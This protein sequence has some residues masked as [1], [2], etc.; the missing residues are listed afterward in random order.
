VAELYDQARPSYPTQLIDNLL[1]LSGV[2]KDQ[3]VLEIGPGTGQLT[4]PLAERGLS[5][6]AVE[7][8]TN[9]ARVARSKLARFDRVEIIVA[10]FN[11]WPLPRQPFDLVVAATAF[12][13][14]DPV[15]RLDRCVQ[16]LRPGGWLAIIDTHW[17]AAVADD[18]FVHASQACYARLDPDHDP[19]A[20]PPGPAG[21]P[22]R[23]EDLASS[24]L[25]PLV[26]RRYRC[27][28]EY[29]AARYCNLLAT[30]SDIRSFEERPRTA[31]LQ[32]IADL[33]ETRFDGRIVRYDVHDLWLGRRK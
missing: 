33:I 25:E 12:H 13:W 21:L 17:G 11:Q 4:L 15:D 26:H 19:N 20:L 30:F 5:L 29:D 23:H 3:R 8:G 24:A 9:L 6:V 28:R 18:A 31:F 7:L 16:A 10:D 1:G 32:C 14:L 2:G 22:E 27:D